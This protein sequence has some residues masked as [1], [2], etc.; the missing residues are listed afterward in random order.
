[1][2]PRGGRAVDRKQPEIENAKKPPLPSAQ[3]FIFFVL[4]GQMTQD[5]RAA[6]DFANRTQSHPAPPL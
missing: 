2:L 6:V 1:M 5:V 4:L 3:F